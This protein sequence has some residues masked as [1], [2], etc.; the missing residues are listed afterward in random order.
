MHY[1]YLLYQKV[2]KSK[3]AFRAQIAHYVVLWPS[4]VR[5]SSRNAAEAMHDGKR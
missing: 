3:S 4:T 5:I 1:F 2:T